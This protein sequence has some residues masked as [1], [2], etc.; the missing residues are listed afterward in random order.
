MALPL[1]AF[2]KPVGATC[3]ARRRGGARRE[4]TLP[5][6]PPATA[7]SPPARPSGLRG[8]TPSAFLGLDGARLAATVG[9]INAAVRP[10]AFDP[11]SLDGCR[12][13]VLEPPVKQ[14]GAQ[15]RHPL[16]MPVRSG[17]ALPLPILAPAWTPRSECRCRM[18]ASRRTCSLRARSWRQRAGPRLFGGDRNDHRQRVRPYR[19]R[20]SRVPCP[21]YRR[22]PLM[23]YHRERRRHSLRL[24]C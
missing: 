18:V 19:W 4:R 10:G 20:G 11:S 15:D 16:T 6:Y 13:D 8:H 12:T 3:R 5:A 17:R 2:R 7:P 24:I 1:A 21:H 22:L 23:R 14:L 9:G